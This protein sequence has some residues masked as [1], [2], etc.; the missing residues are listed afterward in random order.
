MTKY[1][2]VRVSVGS[3]LSPASFGGKSPSDSKVGYEYTG[4]QSIIPK[5]WLPLYWSSRIVFRKS[6]N[7]S[8]GVSFLRVVRTLA[9]AATTTFEAIKMASK[10]TPPIMPPYDSKVKTHCLKHGLTKIGIRSNGQEMSIGPERRDERGAT[11]L[12][13]KVSLFR[14][15]CNQ[16]FRQNSYVVVPEQ[17]SRHQH[18]DFW[19]L[20]CLF[21]SGPL[22]HAIRRGL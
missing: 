18:L 15:S 20:S 5:T 12:K 19:N 7:T 10:I 22:Y 3:L 14:S 16:L 2:T 6:Q 9:P 11:V 4:D 17:K 21:S 1:G 8:T 13:K